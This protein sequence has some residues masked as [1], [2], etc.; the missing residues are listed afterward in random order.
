MTH[1]GH[2]VDALKRQMDQIRLLAT[3]SLHA[4]VQ[5]R[6][7]MLAQVAASRVIQPEPVWPLEPVAAAVEPLVASAPA[8][9]PVTAA[10][11]ESL[12]AVVP[13]LVIEPT[14]APVVVPPAE[15]P[16]AVAPAPVIVPTV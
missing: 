2:D 7:A 8:P 13:A 1:P 14:G 12:A 6:D 16:V 15:P 3:E 5:R 10:S 11:V 4:V 9:V